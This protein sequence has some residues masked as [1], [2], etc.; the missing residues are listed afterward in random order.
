MPNPSGGS[1]ATGGYAA[2]GD[3]TSGGQSGGVGGTAVGG[4]GEMG[5]SPA[6]LGNRQILPDFEADP[7][8]RVFNDEL[9]I[10]P[11]HDI[12]GSNDWVM[13]DWHAFSSTDLVHWT[14]H[15]IIFQLS[16]LTWANRHAW[17]PDCI[18]RNGNY[19]FY[20]PA[21][22]QIGVAV[23]DKPGGYFKDA[24]GKPLI[25]RGEG[26][27]RAIDP[28]IF[29]DDDG[30]A[31]LFYGQNA[32]RVVKMKEDMITRDGAIISV[33]LEKFHEGI[34]MHKR[35]GIYYLSYPSSDGNKASKLEYST[36][37]S[38]LGPF[39]YKGTIIDNNS[40]NIH[41][42]ITEFRGNWYLFYHIQGPSPYERRVFM[43]PL[44]FLPDDTI[45]P[46]GIVTP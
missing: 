43:A 44:I 28:N 29:I 39:E 27:T 31:Y 13:V 22:D 24:L 37:K 34:W 15:G 10:Y 1:G 18:Q 35:N 30:Q 5:S 42:S 14:D 9:W 23:S 21:D 6:V 46:L 25:A 38:V 32:L 8:A 2:V 12:A 4:A 40:R 17:A 33:P 45:Q 36:G 7:S 26:G 20:F 19:Y 16:D 41:G 11:S 3:N